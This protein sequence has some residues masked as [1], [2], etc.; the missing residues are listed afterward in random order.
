M[1]SFWKFLHPLLRRD[2][3]ENT[4][5]DT[6]HA[7]LNAI[8]TVLEEA[9]EDTINAKIQSSL[10]T[11]RGNYLDSWGD[12]FG[13]YRYNKEE[14]DEDYRE[15]IVEALNVPRGTNQSIKIAIRRY[16]QDH[17]VGIQV[18]EPWTDIFYLNRKE[19]RL[20]GEH[21]L[22]GEYYNFAVID[23]SIGEPFPVELEKI[24][25]DFK[26]AGVK[27]HLTYAPSIP[28]T[29]GS[30][31]GVIPY[32]ILRGLPTNTTTDLMNGLDSRIS[33]DIYLSDAKILN[34][35]FR[36]N[37]SLLNGWD[38][39]TG[40]YN[41]RNPF[42][43][44]VSESSTTYKP[45]HNTLLGK[46]RQE[47]NE[48]SPENYYK[49]NGT[50]GDTINVPLQSSRALYFGINLG[51][52][53]GT[54]YTKLDRTRYV[55]GDLLEGA[56]V[57]LSHKA[58]LQG[59]VFSVEAYNFDTNSW[60]LLGKDLT[61]TRVAKTNLELTDSISYVNDNQLLFIRVVPTASYTLNI[62]HFSINYSRFVE[63]HEESDQY[64]LAVTS[65]PIISE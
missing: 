65:D 49:L 37:Q 9:E 21:H 48:I 27:L 39:L 13:V 58:S 34:S 16:L 2:R 44:L 55:Y 8:G 60:D 4:T 29:D 42:L 12:W 19:S 30:D 23:V 26:P 51:E 24:I 41:I 6:N 15:R 47:T 32:S 35:I 5:S 31:Q 36:L 38:V 56:S 62:D 45:N 50:N 43:H 59:N 64:G 18:F 10:K 61:S 63:G 53:F 40:G 17:A 1:S 52:L 54:E 7:V 28:R 33:G 25:N 46:F 11:A 14:R 22:I 57:N 20:N 3:K